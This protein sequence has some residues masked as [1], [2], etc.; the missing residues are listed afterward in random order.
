MWVFIR[1]KG[2]FTGNYFEK[3]GGVFAFHGFR[4]RLPTTESEG[5]LHQDR[6]KILTHNRG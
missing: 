4:L 2:A 6:C 1:C 3:S 5:H